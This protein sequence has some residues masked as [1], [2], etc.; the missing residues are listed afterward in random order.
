MADIF[1][2]D[3]AAK[4]DSLRQFQVF[5]AALFDPSDII[6]IRCIGKGRGKKVVHRWITTAGVPEVHDELC[7]LNDRGYCIY[8]GF[9]PRRADGGTT[10]E[11]VEIARGQ[12]LDIDG[13]CT[14]EQLRAAVASAGLPEPSFILESGGG[15]QAVWPLTRPTPVAEWCARQVG[16]NTAVEGADA[17]IKDGPRIMRAPGFRNRKAKH[18]PNFPM[19]RLVVDNGQ[20]H[21]PGS[22]PMGAVFT[23]AKDASGAPTPGSIE[24]PKGEL[25]KFATAFLERG[26]L[27]P[28]KGKEIPSRRG[29][30]FRVA[31]ECCAAGIPQDEASIRISA[32][33]FAAGLDEEQV[34]D[35]RNRQLANAY[36][37]DRT[38]T[39]D[40]ERLP[41][42]IPSTPKAKPECTMTAAGE[43]LVRVV[44]RRGANVHVDT[45]DPGKANAR[46]RFLSD[47][48]KALGEGADVSEID[49]GL[50]AVAVGDQA[51]EEPEGTTEPAGLF[52]P[53][54]DFVRPERFAVSVEDEHV[55]GTTVPK[56]RQGA[57]GI[58]GVWITHISRSCGQREAI[59]LPT[60]IT[61]GGKD[62]Y[63]HPA[64]GPPAVGPNA[65][66]S[67]QAQDYWQTSG[68]DHTPPVELFESLTRAFNDFIDYPAGDAEDTTAVL[69]LW[70]VLTYT[71]GVFQV[72]PFLAVNGPKGS[73]KSRTMDVLAQVVYRAY[74]VTN[75]S[76]ASVFR[77][78]HINGS[79]LLVDEAE[80]LNGGD[81]EVN[82]MATLLASNRRGAVVPRCEGEDNTVAHFSIFGP[83]AF[84]SIQEPADTLADRSIRIPMLRSPKGSPK[85]LLHPTGRKFQARWQALRDGL[86]C[87]VM[88]YGA[89]LVG[90]ADPEGLVPSEMFPR[91]REVWGPIMQ[92][93][94]LF[95]SLGVA[96][97]SGRM[98]AFALVRSATAEAVTVDPVDEAILRAFVSLWGDGPKLVTS[99]DVVRKVYAAGLD[100][101]QPL[102]GKAVGLTLRRYGIRHGTGRHRKAWVSS[103]EHL[104]EIDRNYGIGLFDSDAEKDPPPPPGK[105]G[106]LGT[107]GTGHPETAV[108]PEENMVSGGAPFSEKSG[109]N[110]APDGAGLG[111]D[112]TTPR[113]TPEPAGAQSGTPEPVGAP[114]S[115]GLGTPKTPEIP[116]VFD[117]GDQCALCAQF[118]GGVPPQKSAKRG[119]VEL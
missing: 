93:A 30:A 48:I 75:P 49:A 35:F 55:S 80:N 87:F 78:L 54:D 89:H 66:W 5:L 24:M 18:G 82:L 107:S 38:P 81:T 21:D 102:T 101:N 14:V 84:F 61:V 117:G 106:T 50:K 115:D 88:N 28:T 83:K 60:N 3:P 74:P 45:L 47:C 11:D 119:R 27:L 32:R 7:T 86:F 26:E 15:C 40:A 1:E 20:R 8:Y 2:D 63:I 33:L 43:G 51:A 94:H 64:I 109:T 104:Q 46:K 17:T 91:S 118:P 71:A 65:G 111:T 97:L 4:A 13:G 56:F 52:I 22:F 37:K 16:I 92:L 105:W 62:F 113:A 44:A 68:K 70:T 79:T 25:P 19:A 90:L 29:T 98:Q 69:A 58:E 41:K 12:C 85:A 57:D 110:R 72:V 100:T 95:E 67:P 23:P 34:N 10:A 96:G 53:V 31:I 6:E 108:N 73:G 103:R 112:T 36:A 76:A 39:I 42:T 59:E 9:N 99:S 114:F 116:G 77:E